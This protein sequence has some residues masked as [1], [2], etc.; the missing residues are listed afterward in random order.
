MA[1]PSFAVLRRLA[2]ES[3]RA[4]IQE[5]DR[6]FLRERADLK[7]TLDALITGAWMP[8]RQ[9]RRRPP[10]RSRVRRRSRVS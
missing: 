9:A 1:R 8:T 5:L 7:A 6:H 2:I 10:R 3:T 4:R